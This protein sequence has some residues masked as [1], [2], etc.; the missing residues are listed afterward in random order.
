MR[1]FI[2][3]LPTKE[4]PFMD[5]TIKIRKLSAG[6]VKKIGDAAKD[7]D[8]AENSGALGMLEIILKEGVVVDEGEEITVAILEEF[9]LADLTTLSNAIM[10]FAGLN[11]PASEGN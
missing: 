4:I 1:K 7:M 10:E 8:V 2:K 11:V 3:S 5:E 6:S 9:P